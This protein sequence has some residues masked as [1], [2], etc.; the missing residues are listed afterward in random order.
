MADSPARRVT[1]VRASVFV[2]RRT[3]S[4][5][6]HSAAPSDSTATR[7]ET[8]TCADA[9]SLNEIAAPGRM[10]SVMVGGSAAALRRHSVSP[11]AVLA[12]E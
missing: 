3:V 7:V 9:S 6:R 5:N 10:R 11:T 2:P 1:D 4:V 12:S 8:V